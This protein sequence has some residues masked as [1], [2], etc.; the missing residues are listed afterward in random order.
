MKDWRI[1]LKAIGGYDNEMIGVPSGG[2][3]EMVEDIESLQKQLANREKQIVML[4]GA[5]IK[6]RDDQ[7]Q[8]D[9]EIAPWIVE[10]LDATDDLSGCILCDAEPVGTTAPDYG[11]GKCFAWIAGM[12]FEQP[13]YKARKP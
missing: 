6:E 5:L 3:K 10:A 8:N 7:G 12:D 9:F 11:T 4:R 13:L 2:V 1:M